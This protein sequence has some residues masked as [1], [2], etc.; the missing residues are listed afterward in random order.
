MQVV[1]TD[2]ENLQQIGRV[3]GA[4]KPRNG[5]VD[6]R[7]VSSQEFG[8]GIMFCN[9]ESAITGCYWKGVA[10]AL[11]VPE[12]VYAKECTWKKLLVKTVAEAKVPKHDKPPPSWTDRLFD[13]MLSICGGG[14]GTLMMR[15]M[16]QP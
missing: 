5:Q 9:C 2:V 10:Q 14:H 7:Q 4:G 16:H 1:G 13:G 3:R 8:R 11:G 12:A 6:C 15:Q